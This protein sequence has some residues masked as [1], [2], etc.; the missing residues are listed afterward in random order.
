MHLYIVFSSRKY[1]I[2]MPT[3]CLKTRA[4]KKIYHKKT[5][6]FNDVSFRELFYRIRVLFHK[7]Q[8]TPSWDKVFVSTLIICFMSHSWT[9]SFTLSFFCWG[10]G[11]VL[12]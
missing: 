3:F 1:H 2:G 11:G 7:I 6:A 12:M 8:F 9:N 10:G 4:P 5:R